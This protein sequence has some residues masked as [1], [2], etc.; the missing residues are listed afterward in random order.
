MQSG[1]AGTADGPAVSRISPEGE[2]WAK[3]RGLSRLTLER[4]GVASGIT[5]FPAIERKEEGLFFRFQSGWKARCV[6]V[7]THVAGGGWKTAFW[8]IDAVIAASPKVVYFTEGEPD[9][10]ALVEAGIEPSQVLSVPNGARET[11]SDDPKASPG[12]Q[13]VE[14]ALK[15]GLNKVEKFVWC[16]DADI[17]GHALRADMV[18]LLGAARFH[19]VDWPEGCKDANDYLLSDGADA[20]YEMA[21]HGSLPWPVSGLYRLSELPEPPKFTLWRPGFA[22]WESKVLLAP[23]TLSVVT[24]HPGHGKTQLWTQIWFQIVRAYCI[25][26]CIASFE[27]RAKPHVRR[28]LRSLFIGKLEKDLSQ[29]EMARA[30]AWI[31]ERYLFIEHKEQRPTLEWLLDMAE[32]AVIRHGARIVQI[33]PWN[34]LESQRGGNETET[35][36]ILRCLRTIY[37]F[38]TDMNCHVQIV[39]HPTKMDAARKGKPPELDDIAGSKHWDNVVDQGFVVHRPEM[40]DGQERKTEAVMY[41]RKSRFEELGFQ[42]KLGMNYDLT[43]GAYVSTDYKTGAYNG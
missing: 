17:A 39:A 11:E 38:A 20:L 27:T 5:F 1:I 23:R 9:A 15:A 32:V 6:P 3:A 12:Y 30:D 41:C 8:N 25:P 35:E 33:D 42:C 10:L 16:G 7:K 34:R 14:E 31:N 18:R 19:F 40:F 2:A 26:A 13:Y 43:R 28:Q 24:G 21:V 29:E 4:M 36:Y 22:E 37:V